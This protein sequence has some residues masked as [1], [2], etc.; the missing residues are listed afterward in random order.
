MS[1]DIS[2]I[3]ALQVQWNAVAIVYTEL[4]AV[5]SIMRRQFRVD[6][7]IRQPGLTNIGLKR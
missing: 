7:S 5:L 3:D 1:L 2:R 4:A 6:L